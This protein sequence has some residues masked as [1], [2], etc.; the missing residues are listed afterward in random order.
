MLRTW[1][2]SRLS[3]YKIPS[4]F[5]FYSKAPYNANG[6]IDL[7][8]LRKSFAGDRTMQ[9]PERSVPVDPSWAAQ[10]EYSWKKVLNKSTLTESDHFFETGGDSLLAI[11][12]I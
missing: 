10:V 4:A 8:A 1:L 3:D 2:A 5:Y 6:K 11:Q 9:P 7:G 12:I